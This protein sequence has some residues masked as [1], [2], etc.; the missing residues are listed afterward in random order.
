MERRM[1]YK[2][3]RGTKDILP[4][5]TWRWQAVEA[6]FRELCRLAGFLEIRTPTFEET[7][8]FT[9]SIGEV[10]DVVSKEM[11][12]FQDRSGRDLTLRPEGTAPVVRAWVENNLG[13][14]GLPGKLFYIGRF[15]EN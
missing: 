1:Q 6:R 10:T 4:S 7:Q 15:H 3:P 13:A 5:E 12:S 11:Y 14:Q 2:A 8:L 9:R